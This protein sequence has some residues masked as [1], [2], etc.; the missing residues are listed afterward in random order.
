MELFSL[1]I[2]LC[3]KLLEMANK[4]MDFAR[5]N[6]RFSFTF[7]AELHLWM[8]HEMAKINMEEATSRFLNHKV[9]GMTISNSKDISSDSL[10]SK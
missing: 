8:E 3:L 2:L 9:T 5:V 4:V 7:D 6:E 10:A 1:L